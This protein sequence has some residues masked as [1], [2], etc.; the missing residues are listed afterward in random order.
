MK[1]YYAILGV[2]QAA[3]EGAIRHAFRTQARR[4]HPDAGPGGSAEQFREVVEAYDV[5]RD[6]ARREQYDR[7]LTLQSIPPEPLIPTRSPQSVPAHVY[8]QS[9]YVDP[10]TL[11]ET[12]FAGIDEL[13]ELLFDL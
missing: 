6:R 10:F 9:A 13:F 11:A 2:R 12:L 5:L 3:D 4:H 8:F 7:S 1:N